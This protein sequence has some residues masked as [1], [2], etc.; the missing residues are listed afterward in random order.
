MAIST[1]IQKGSLV[2]VYDEKN[3]LLWTSSGELH[4]YTGSS[5]SIKKGNIIYVYDEKQHQISSHSC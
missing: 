4:G 1:A 3:H 5:V 2:Y